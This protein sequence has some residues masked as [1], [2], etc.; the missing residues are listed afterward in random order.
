MPSIDLTGHTALV[1]GGSGE[2]GRVLCRNLAACGAAIAVHY[3]AGRERAEAVVAEI[4][5][6]GG[7][8]L[9]V[10]AD[11]TDAN[12]VLAMRDTI[13]QGLGPV[14]IL[15]PNAVIQY[16][17]TSVLEQDV[18][19]YESQFRSCVVQAV[20]LAKA[21]VPDM[22]ARG[23]GRIVATNTEC[24]MQC[25]PGQSAYVAGKGGMDRLLRVLA[26]EVG[27]DG[28][29]V[30]QV[31]PGWMISD[32]YRG[33]GA[34]DDSG[35]IERTPLPLGHR[36]EDQDIANAVCFLASDLARFITGAYLPVCGGNVM[37]AV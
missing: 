8:A 22:R 5:A 3:H 37:P 30:N 26:K 7:R 9:A 11:I 35:Y 31:A 23:W 32:K 12:S 18:A 17:W 33:E 6:E 25:W 13:K 19:D 10:A 4:V 29:T 34:I 1:T 20:L 16:Q 27:S 28:I 24:T 2:L 21:F 36:G 15:V 14:S